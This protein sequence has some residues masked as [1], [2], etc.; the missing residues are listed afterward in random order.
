METTA[1]HT[2]RWTL[3][4][5]ARGETPQAREALRELCSRCYT[6]VIAFLRREGRDEESARELAHEFFAKVLAGDTLGQ[7]DRDRGRFR[8]YLL[9]AVK[10]F[11]AN[12]RRDA[13]R[14]KRGGGAEHQPLGENT[15]TSP[16]I[17]I[18]DPSALPSDNVFDREWA[19]AIIGRALVH[20][21]Q[22]STDPAQF[23]ALKPWLTPA[24]LPSS[25]AETAV[26]LGVTEGAL[27]VAIHRLRKRF[28][29]LVRTEV[30]LTLLEPSDLDDEMHH[31]V[32]ALA[33]SG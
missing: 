16:G 5:N 4:H 12:H 24:G 33:S 18:P 20:L 13:T 23:A 2:T 22:E 30:S 11:L 7:A 27:K 14:E 6:P 25:Q 26:Q 15:D 17:Q 1:F 3:V 19:L 9:G 21:E 8:T 32:T 31:L 29:L 28:R 10:H